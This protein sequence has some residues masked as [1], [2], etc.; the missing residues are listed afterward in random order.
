MTTESTK[1]QTAT[2]GCGGEGGCGGTAIGVDD[3][4]SAQVEAT[5]LDVRAIPHEHRH[6]RVI[7]AV[8]SLVPGEALVVAAPHDPV[9]LLRQIEVEVAGDFSVDYL[10]SGPVVWRVSI[11][12]VTCC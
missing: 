4:A 11:A 7:G 6:A 1:D 8:T 9:P 12:R 2:C 10:Q 5:D 3:L